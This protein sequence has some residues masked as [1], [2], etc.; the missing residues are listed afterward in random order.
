MAE[1]VFGKPVDD[2]VKEINDKIGI[3]PSGQTVEGQI[4]ALNSKLTYTSGTPTLVPSTLTQ[5]QSLWEKV[6]NVVSFNVSFS[7]IS[8]S[9]P[10]T[11]SHDAVI[12]T[13]LP[14]P[15][16]TIYF[17]AHCMKSGTKSA[18]LLINTSGTVKVYWDTLTIPENGY[19]TVINLTYVV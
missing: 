7:S 17:M 10:T 1:S 11:F 12:F 18:R 8:A 2:A 19:S 14:A 5:E 13:G 9:S 6:G 3:V 4:D 15:K 16:R